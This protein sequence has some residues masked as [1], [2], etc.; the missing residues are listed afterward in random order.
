MDTI[1]EVCCGSYY[2]AIQAIKGHA[3]RI[4]LNSALHIGG[5][6]PDVAALQ[7]IKEK[8]SCK[9]ITMIRPRGAGFCYQQ[10]DFENMEK[11]AHVMLANNADGIAFGCLDEFGNVHEEQTKIMVDI[12]KQ[13]H[14]EA[15][16]HRAFDCTKD[17]YQAI[18]KLIDLGVDRILTSGQ[19]MKAIQGIKL[20][21]ELQERYGSKIEIV[22]GSGIHAS[23][24]LQIIKE[25]NITQVHSSCKRWLHD[26][27]TALG[28]VTYSY[29]GEEHRMEYDVVDAA[30]VA[31]LVAQVCAG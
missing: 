30:L 18:E 6:T 15:V 4:E 19:Q 14:A 24:A 9:V 22:A 20:L 5:L 26:A 17:P 16:F 28:K 31:Q 10:E 7:L 2:D 23:N 12:A 11:A 1:V 27:T 13:A 8:H 21:K 25:T 3:S 29:A